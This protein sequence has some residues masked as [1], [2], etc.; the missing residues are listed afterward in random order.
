[1]DAVA[2]VDGRKVNVSGHVELDVGQ[3]G[4]FRRVRLPVAVGVGCAGVQV[5]LFG[6]DVLES[7]YLYSVADPV[8]VGV[9]VKGVRTEF[10]HFDA[11]FQTITVGVGIVHSGA[12][13]LF[14]FIGQA[15]VVG[16]GGVVGLIAYCVI[17]CCVLCGQ[18]RR[19]GLGGQRVAVRIEVPGVKLGLR[20]SPGSL[21]FLL[22]LGLSL[23]CG[24]LLVECVYLVTLKEGGDDHREDHGQRHGGVH[25][26]GTAMDQHQDQQA[27]CSRKHRRRRQDP[28]AVGRGEETGK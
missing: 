1:M 28:R 12:E 19:V 18:G 27:Q 5:P 13:R 20:L 11:V 2:K 21:L 6:V 14:L 17:A 3:F 8:A 25:L 23:R 22:L 10:E 9:G 24:L 15:V 7:P 16:I 26:A 4:T